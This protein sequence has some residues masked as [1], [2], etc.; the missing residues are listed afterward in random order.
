[1]SIRNV[2]QGI[3]AIQV[4]NVEEGAR[5]LRIALKSQEVNGSMRGIACLWLAEVSPD[6]GSKR[7][8]YEEALASDPNNAQIRQRVEGWMATQMP[9]PPPSIPMPPSVTPRPQQPAAPPPPPGLPETGNLYQ[10]QV[11]PPGAPVPMSSFAPRQPAVSAPASPSFQP[12]VGGGTY[13]VVGV[14]GGPNGP[15]T[16]FFVAREGLLATTRYV[17]GGMD[18]VTVQLDTGRQ[19]AGHVVRAFPEVDLAFIYV[20]LVVN[21]LIPVSPLP[22]LPDET[23][24]TVVSYNGQMVRGRRRAT[25]RVLSPQWFPTD[26]TTVPDAG[27]CPV[28]DDRHYLVGMITRNATST[29]SYVHGL[30]IGTI[31]QM[32]EI[33]RQETMSGNR[34]Y[35][36]HCGSY[37]QAPAGGGYYCEICGALTPQAERVVRFPQPQTDHFYREHSRMSCMYCN[38]TV[39]FHKG[40]CLR[41]GRAP[42]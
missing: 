12:Q 16:A 40:A 35:C 25:K 5:L 19:M 7:Q 36:P 39:G 26:I 2:E 4:G 1:M 31:R 22:Q 17:V 18:Q 41:C 34:L 24:L 9:P 3:A 10:S 21:D 38:A 37:S 13:T 30:N 28:L 29:S 15:G 11:V 33:F 14:I 27:G 42:S 6:V 23:P 20:E 32:V 8:Y